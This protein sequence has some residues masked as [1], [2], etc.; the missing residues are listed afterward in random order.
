MYKLKTHSTNK[1]T[2]STNKKTHSTNKKHNAQIKKTQYKYNIFK[3][4]IQ[5]FQ[6]T[7]KNTKYK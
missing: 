1:K 3:V 5:Y 6:S 2:H 7:S 4:Q